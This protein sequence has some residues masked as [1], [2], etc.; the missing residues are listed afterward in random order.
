MI[1]AV[2]LFV[3]NSKV[4]TLYRR[5]PVDWSKPRNFNNIA[6]C[7]GSGPRVMI[8][9]FRQHDLLQRTLPVT[10][11]QRSIIRA[12][13]RALHPTMMPLSEGGLPRADFECLVNFFERGTTSLWLE[14]ET[15]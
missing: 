8:P 3:D 7:R 10:S 1:F 2:A 14:G 4:E 15:D 9:N 6:Q 12:F 13:F 11:R 5:M